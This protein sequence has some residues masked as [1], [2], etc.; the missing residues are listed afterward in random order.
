MYRICKRVQFQEEENEREQ[1]EEKTKRRREKGG[2]VIA[3]HAKHRSKNR[4]D[5]RRGPRLYDDVQSY[6]PCEALRRSATYYGDVSTACTGFLRFG[7]SGG[8]SNLLQT[9]TASVS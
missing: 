6:T 9:S 8:I 1:E 3:M 5:K 7:G 2:T 4:D